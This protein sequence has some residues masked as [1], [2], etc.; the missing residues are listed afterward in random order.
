MLVIRAAGMT[1]P[2]LASILAACLLSLIAAFQAL[3][4]LGMPFGHAA[5]GGMH[6]VL[7]PHLRVASAISVAPL[8]LAIWIILS[9][10]PLP[11]SSTHLY[12]DL[13]IS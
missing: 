4:A 6:R 10:T 12:L 2:I 13:S 7:P 3:L 9:S 1:A 5:W 8:V 11:R